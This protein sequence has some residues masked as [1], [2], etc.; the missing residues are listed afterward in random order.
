MKYLTV[1]ISQL[2]T[3]GD[4]FS[5]IFIWQDNVSSA[6]S[7]RGFPISLTSFSYWRLTELW[8]RYS[9][10]C[11]KQNLTFVSFEE[12]LQAEPKTDTMSPMKKSSDYCTLIFFGRKLS[13]G[14]Q[15]RVFNWNHVQKL[16]SKEGQ[17]LC[18][19][20]RLT[21]VYMLVFQQGQHTKQVPA[22]SNI[23]AISKMRSC[24]EMQTTPWIKLNTKG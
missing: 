20:V 5:G 4:A 8:A 12:K 15:W 14:S 21:T 18:D 17:S 19:T 10:L 22:K 11:S 3:V 7:L 16:L 23:Y 1:R 24:R 2:Y 9:I 13:P 6:F